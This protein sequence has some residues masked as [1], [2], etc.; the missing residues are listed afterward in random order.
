MYEYLNPTLKGTPMNVPGL[1]DHQTC[2]S[3]QLKCVMMSRFC[4]GHGSDI[5][6][7][8]GLTPN[9]FEEL[10]RHGRTF[11]ALL[12]IPI[13]SNE[14]CWRSKIHTR[15]NTSNMKTAICLQL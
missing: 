2:L 13:Y 11:M 9:E 3:R 1:T 7:K 12:Y 14:S 5:I 10:G 4:E 6:N 8:K 15:K